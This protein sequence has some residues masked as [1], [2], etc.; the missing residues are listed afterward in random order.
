MGLR[1]RP[2]VFG[3]GAEVGV[4]GLL[5]GADSMSRSSYRVPD[6]VDCCRPVA[7]LTIALTQIE[8]EALARLLDDLDELDHNHIF[9][10]AELLLIEHSRG[11]TRHTL[12][13]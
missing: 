2:E 1:L 6:K 4:L 12:S 5:S 7:A 11:E 9:T 8:T 3:G 10:D 13:G